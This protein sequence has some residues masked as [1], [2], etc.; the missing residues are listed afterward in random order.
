LPPRQLDANKL[1]LCSR[2]LLQVGL[3]GYT[4]NI[5]IEVPFHV[6]VGKEPE[7]RAL[8]IA[9]VHGD[10]YEGVAVLQDLA[11]EIDPAELRGTLTIVPV[12]NPQAFY[13]RARRHPVDLADLNR[14]FPGNPNGT[15]S[16]RL[17][18]L[19]FR[20]LVLGNDYVLS[21][22]C[23]GHDATV[24]PYIEHQEDQSP[25]GKKAAAAALALGLEF[26][27]PYQWPE[28][29]LALAAIRNGIAAI[30]PEVGGL[31][32]LTA[33]GRR[34]YQTIAYRFLSHLQM[35]KAPEAALDPPHPHPKIVDHSDCF[36]SYAGL[37]RRYVN[38]GDKV[39]ENHLLGTICDL[40]GRTLEEIRAP[41]AGTVASTRVFSSVQ[42]GERIVQVFWEK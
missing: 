37:L 2:N 40:A 13:A 6:L 25:A 5:R 33:A 7:P 29:L 11:K 32:T 16:E 34:A 10:E 19:L 36:A 35:V 41:R 3:P 39:V 4:G 27:H 31:G 38:A 26:I 21:M 18:D 30:E 14:S 20:E 1:T 23:W 15:I 22:H 17:A 12:A 8:L 42:P 28:G 9:G 24:I